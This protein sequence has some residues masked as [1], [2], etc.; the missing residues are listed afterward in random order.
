MF[1]LFYGFDW[2]GLSGNF[3]RAIALNPNDSFAHDQFAMALT[4]QG[5]FPEAIA[6]GAR[7]RAGSPVSQ[8]LVDATMPF[9]FQRKLTE[10]MALYGKGGR[11]QCDASF[12]S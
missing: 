9:L 12:P 6:E 5:R 4:F 3:R 8:V 11:T 7:D 1:K 2:E 10:A